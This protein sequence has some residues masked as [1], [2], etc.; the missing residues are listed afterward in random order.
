MARYLIRR[1]FEAIPTLFFLTVIAFFFI[2]AA[3]GD[4]VDVLIDPVL[5][6]EQGPEALAALRQQFGLDQPAPIQY[7]NWLGQVVTGNLGY[8]F[9]QRRPVNAMIG[10]RL[11]GTLQLAIPALILAVI[12]GVAA[13]VISSLKQYS[14]LDHT[15]SILSY[16]A[17]SLPNF[18][19]GL[20]LIYIF[21]VQLHWLPSAGMFAPN[22]EFDPI[23]RVRHLVLPVGVL[24][25]Q[26]LGLFARQT[27]S[28][29]LEVIGSEYVTT[30]RAKGLKEK[31]VTL[32]HMLPNALIPIITVIGMSLPLLVTGAIIT[33]TVFAWSGMG[34]LTMNAI[35]SRDYP[36]LMGVIVVIG[37]GVLVLNL[38]IDVLY[39]VVDPRI[40][41]S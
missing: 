5:A 4:V 25:V 18:Y 7:A 31:V 37:F 23:D 9:I 6:K 1:L 29:M 30:A 26:F 17:W 22:A 36:V 41:Y 11:G 20:I 34:A 14:L 21:A 8:S 16:G 24:G 40:R 28:A 19:L 15:I 10:E 38:I 39:A 27:R 35:L 33:E 3:P 12:L 13:G 32:R 2:D